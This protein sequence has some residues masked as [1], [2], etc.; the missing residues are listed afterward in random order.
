MPRLRT[1]TVSTEVS[2]EDYEMC[3]Q[4]AGD[5]RSA[6]GSVEVLFRTALAERTV[7]DW[8]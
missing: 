4:L 3:E 6:N 8:A 5:Q 1:R 2:E 7:E